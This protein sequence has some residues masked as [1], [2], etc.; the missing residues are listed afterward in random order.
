[1][2]DA[3][4]TSF[5][6]D[7]SKVMYEDSWKGEVY[8]CIYFI[9]PKEWLG[10]R[11]PEAISAEIYMAFPLDNCKAEFASVMMSPTKQ[12]ESGNMEDYDWF[13]ISLD[14]SEINALMKLANI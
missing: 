9:A 3:N 1:M 14:I 5:D 10:D 8:H 2:M 7:I 12:D 11:Y 6:F 4:R 13:D